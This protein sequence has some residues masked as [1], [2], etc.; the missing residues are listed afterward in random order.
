MVVCVLNILNESVIDISKTFE[1]LNFSL[2]KMLGS[3]EAWE[4]WSIVEVPENWK[5]CWNTDVFEPLHHMRT[6]WLLATRGWFILMSVSISRLLSFGTLPSYIF[7]NSYDLHLL[8]S[9]IFKMSPNRETVRKC[10]NSWKKEPIQT[11]KTML[12]G[13]PW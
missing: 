4:C 11:P 6:V 2:L 8:K 12:D 9:I 5:K 3:A 10:N 7:P 1:L 13:L